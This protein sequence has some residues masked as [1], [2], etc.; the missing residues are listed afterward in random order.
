MPPTRDNTDPVRLGQYL[1]P[2][3]QVTRCACIEECRLAISRSL[4][5]GVTCSVFHR[6]G[7]RISLHLA[8]LLVGVS[9]LITVFTGRAAAMNR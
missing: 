7:T 5:I 9:Q 2:I 4:Y 1:H 3:A 6:C 8:R